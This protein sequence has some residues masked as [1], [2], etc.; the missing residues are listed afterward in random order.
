MGM[1]LFFKLYLFVNHVINVLIFLKENFEIS[2][3]NLLPSKKHRATFTVQYLVDKTNKMRVLAFSISNYFYF[4]QHT[5]LNV[6]KNSTTPALR[7]Y[8]TIKV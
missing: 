7:S 3:F 1:R 4:Y 2:M 8:V 5:S 6:A